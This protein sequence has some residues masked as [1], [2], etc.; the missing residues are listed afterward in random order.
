MTFPNANTETDIYNLRFSNKEIT[1]VEDI[2][3]NARLNG[4]REVSI[5]STSF[6]SLTTNPQITLDQ[7]IASTNTFVSGAFSAEFSTDFASEQAATTPGLDFRYGGDPTVLAIIING[8]VQFA[9]T[10]VTP[11]SV[12]GTLDLGSGTSISLTTAQTLAEVVIAINVETVTSGIQATAE[13]DTNTSQYYLRLSKDNLTDLSVLKILSTS[14]ASILTDF[15]ILA[16]NNGYSLTPSMLPDQISILTI[17]PINGVVTLRLDDASGVFLCAG[18]AN[19]DLGFVATVDVGVDTI[20]ITGHGLVTGDIITFESDNGLP[21]PLLAYPAWYYINRIDDNCF[22]VSGIL[23]NA[24]LN[25]VEDITE[26]GD[27]RFTVREI[28]EAENYYNVWSD[29]LTS[30]FVYYRPYTERINTFIEHFTL[31]DY[32]VDVFEDITNKRIKWIIRW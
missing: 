24:L 17:V 4:L 14:T 18:T 9:T 15:G 30:D 19:S 21:D 27:S 28:T 7:T 2:I 16:N 22:Q 12:D 20:N 31:L 25:I 8:T 11:V 5:T 1:D 32:Q 26:N 10:S 6:T 29:S 23:Q 13:L 3:L